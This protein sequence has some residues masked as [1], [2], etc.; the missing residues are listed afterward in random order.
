MSEKGIHEEMKATAT[1]LSD[2]ESV[3]LE[4]SPVFY[5]CI[6]PACGEDRLECLNH[7]KFWRAD[8]LGF[9]QDGEPGCGYLELDGDSQQ[10]IECGACGHIVCEWSPYSEEQCCPD[11]FIEWALENGEKKETLR[12]NCPVCGSSGLEEAE[13]A[14]VR[15]TIE[16]VYETEG[17]DKGHS[18]AEIAYEEFQFVWSGGSCRYHCSKGHELAKDDG[19][20]VDNPKD[21]VEWLK[22]HN[23]ENKT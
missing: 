10:V 14:E 4:K 20:P 1:T 16:A 17:T 8:L 23:R 6:C 9:T 13:T 3:A 21:L 19:S 12:F 7:G 18:N 15:R 11:F 5:R 2:N 22:A